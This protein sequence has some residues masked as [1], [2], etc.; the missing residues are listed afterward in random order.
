[1]WLIRISRVLISQDHD[2]MYVTIAE[3]KANYIGYLKNQVEFENAGFLLMTTYGPFMTTNSGHMAWLGAILRVLLPYAATYRPRRQ[4]SPSQVPRTPSP[5]ERPP[6]AKRGS[7]AEQ[8]ERARG[9]RGESHGQQP[10]QER[11]PLDRGSEGRSS[12]SS[13]STRDVGKIELPDRTVEGKE[14]IRAHTSGPRR[15][16][17]PFQDIPSGGPASGTTKQ[18][19][20]QYQSEQGESPRPQ[21]DSKK[22]KTKL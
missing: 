8:A 21:T 14:R 18:S 3:Y 6:S 9:R 1:M 11:S 16:L 7:S 12:T 5:A 10:K 2:E 20:T 4:L 22:G 15:P 13:G 17:S 19:I